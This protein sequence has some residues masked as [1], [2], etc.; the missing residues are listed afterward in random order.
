MCHQSLS[1]V[2]QQTPSHYISFSFT[3][4]IISLLYLG[5]HTFKFTDYN[6]ICITHISRVCHIYPA[7]LIRLDL[8]TPVIFSEQH[9]SWSSSLRCCTTLFS[10]SP[11]V[12][13]NIFLSTLFRGTLT[14]MFCTV[15]QTK[16]HTNTYLHHVTNTEMNLWVPQNSHIFFAPCATISFPQTASQSILLCYIYADDTKKSHGS[17]PTTLP[18]SPHH[19]S[20]TA[21][22]GTQL[23]CWY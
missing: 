15:W 2:I 18:S 8:V 21:P 5:L 1:S 11:P 13:P 6:S 20:L 17:G 4:N 16:F 22:A 7:H 23:E 12:W 14:L 19:P 9:K 10:L 3:F